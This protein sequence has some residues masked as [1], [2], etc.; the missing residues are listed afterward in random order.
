MNIINY[1]CFMIKSIV[2]YIT[3]EGA[4]SNWTYEISYINLDTNTSMTIT[5]ITQTS[6]RIDNLQADTYYK[7]SVLAYK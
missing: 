5:G 4:W 6:Y 1:K 2:L 3:A 7:I